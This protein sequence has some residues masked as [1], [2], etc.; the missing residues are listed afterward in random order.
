MKRKA[1]S[2]LST[3]IDLTTCSDEDKDY[4]FTSSK[5]F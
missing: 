2:M 4:L 1:E 3:E 5:L